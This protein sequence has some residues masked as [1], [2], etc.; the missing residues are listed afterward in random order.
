MT[1]GFPKI[2]L[3]WQDG[4]AASATYVS[5]D[6]AG[7]MAWEVASPSNFNYDNRPTKFARWWAFLDMSSSH[8]SL[9][10]TYDSGGVFDGGWEYDSG[11]TI[12]LTAQAMADIA[13]MFIDWKSAGDWLNGVVLVWPQVGGAP[14]PTPGG[15]PTQDAAGWW[16]LPAGHWGS[17][18]DPGDG[19]GTR[20]PNF[21]WIYDNPAP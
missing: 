4:A 18:V 8:F 6:S 20:P 3:V 10:H 21:T 14:F 17:L 9:P 5:I 1:T 16:S 19:R 7:T 12:P 2:L 13:Q 15:T 11:S